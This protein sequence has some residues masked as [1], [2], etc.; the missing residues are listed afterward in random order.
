MRLH[1]YSVRLYPKVTVQG[2]EAR[3]TKQQAIVCTVP[4]SML[5][6]TESAILA[7]YQLPI[8]CLRILKTSCLWLSLPSVRK[9]RSRRQ[10][11][12]RW[13]WSQKKF[14]RSKGWQKGFLEIK[15]VQASD[16]L[17][18]FLDW[19]NRRVVSNRMASGSRTRFW[20]ETAIQRTRT[21]KNPLYQGSR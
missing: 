21:E 15:A 2:I 12:F 8:H 5:Y 16:R 7:I 4:L 20:Q 14:A 11:E 19:K 3:N 6:T 9:T 18:F 10:V 1:F 17:V 13:G